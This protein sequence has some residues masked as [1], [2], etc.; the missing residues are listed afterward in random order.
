M[1]KVDSVKL[2]K[3]SINIKD[4]PNDL[5]AQFVMDVTLIVKAINYANDNPKHNYFLK[6]I[7]PESDSSVNDENWEFHKKLLNKYNSILPLVSSKDMKGFW[8]M[9]Y[10]GGEDGKEFI[11]GVVFNNISDIYY[12]CIDMPSLHKKNKDKISNNEELKK[13]LTRL[14]DV[15]AK[16]EMNY[17]LFAPNNYDYFVRE[18]IKEKSY[19]DTSEETP[20]SD[21]NWELYVKDEEMKSLQNNLNL[22]IE[23]IRERLRLL[24]EDE[25]EKELK[26]YLKNPKSRKNNTDGSFEIK[27]ARK[28]YVFFNNTY[29]NPYYKYIVVILGILFGSTY[30]Y[31]DIIKFTKKVRDINNLLKQEENSKERIKLLPYY[32]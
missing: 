27:M 18:K 9:L 21:I 10:S 25:F 2:E 17:S 4:I 13:F 1:N 32:F 24:H 12:D 14:E 28:L 6:E 29:G 23:T 30:D 15:N 3:C 11:F 16:L 22:L 20:F 8:N 31:N 5:P 26:S 7:N 19:L